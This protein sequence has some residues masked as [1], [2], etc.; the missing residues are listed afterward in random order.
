MRPRYWYRFRLARYDRRVAARIALILPYWDFWERSVPGDLRAEREQLARRA[1]EALAAEVATVSVVA[2]EADGER[3]AREAEAAGAEALLVLQTMAV[4]PTRALA[5]LG[6]L[7]V[8]VWALAGS[9]RV[10]DR[11]DHG[12]ITASGATVG[13]PML[14][15]V[16]VRRGRPFELVVAPLEEP[17][18]VDRALA[19][20]AAARALRAARI[21]R[22]G[23]PLPGYECVDADDARLRAETGITL[24]PVEPADVLELY[25]GVA[26]ERVREL[27]Q[28]TRAAYAVE[29]AGDGLARTLRAACA[30]EDLVERY[31]LDAGAM[32]CHVPEI[33]FG[34]EIGI[35]P[36]FGL[37]RMTSRGVPWSCTGDVLTAVA[38]LAAKL[39]GGC[40][41]Y[42]ELEALDAESGEFVI[43]SSGEHDLELAPGVRPRLVRN[44]WFAADP[45]CGAC[46]CF[47]APAG[48]ATLL[49]FAQLERGYRLIVA[50]GELTGRGWPGVGTAN[51]AFRFAGGPP[52][53]AWTRW[54]RAGSNHHS[55]ATRGHHAAGVETVA[56]FLAVDFVSV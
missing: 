1:A 39:V 43:A 56:R 41:Q 17:A 47:T 21:G 48:P 50:E 5:A 20:A 14:T 26:E 4:P 11:F 44:E 46:A 52:G 15:S 22:I 7:P 49:A 23:R 29:L 13:T 30:L 53:E 3:A 6:E 18:A 27:E 37:G 55:A 19:G 36:C 24:V 16:L 8:V 32:N 31:R 12:G 38:L 9:G 35:A 34:D 2:S 25:R 54:C 45:L 33:R 28:E 10:P 51:A 42:H 40:A